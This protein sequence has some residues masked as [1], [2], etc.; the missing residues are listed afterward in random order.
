MS[1]YGDRC[2]NPFNLPVHRKIKDLRKL[3]Q[4]LAKKWSITNKNLYVC[5]QCR[6][7]LTREVPLIISDNVLLSSQSSQSSVQNSQESQG[8]YY[9]PEENTLTKSTQ[10]DDVKSNDNE[11]LLQLKEKFNDPSTS[12]SMKTMILTLAPKSWSEKKLADEFRT[13]RRQAKKAKELVEQNGILSSPN[14]RE[15]RKLTSEVRDLV[16]TFYLREDNTRI[17]PGKKDFVSVKLHDGNR[18]HL[19]KQLIMCNINELYQQFKLEYPATKVGLSK[20]FSLRPKQCILAGDSGTHV[21]CVCIYHQNVKLMLSGGN[22]SSLTS[23]SAIPLTSYKDCL[24]KMMCPDPTPTCHLMTGK[25]SLNEQC[26]NCPGLD[27]IREHLTRI[28]D[29]NQ[30]TNV[31]FDT[32]VGTDSFT[33]TTRVL[34]SDE[35]VDSL[36]SA[37]DILKPHAYIADQQTRYF[38][39]LKESILEGENIIQCDFAENY[40]FV[41]QDAAQSFHWNNDQATLLTSVFYYKKDQNLKHGSIVMISDDLKHDTATY[42]TFQKLLHQHLHEKS[43]STK[44]YIY[45]TDGAS[46]HFKNRFNFINLFYFKQDFGTDAEFHFHATSHGKGPCDGLGGNLKRLATRA[47]LQSASNNAITTSERLYEWARKSLPQ[48]HVFYARKEDIQQ[49]RIFLKSRFESA[50]T[51]PGTKKYHAFIPITEG[52]MVKHTSNSEAFKIVKICK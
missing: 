46:Q 52:I 34:P 41:V 48:T 40:S 19:Q 8:L 50:A 28:F 23:E 47:S 42:Y 10:T 16:T 24:Q 12:V 43:I 1:P 17:L 44:K 27:E 38:Q 30:V 25:S 15:G 49:N 36:C 3:S 5:K 9:V 31:Q 13:S 29:E 18:V 22:I 11:I 2:Y 51:I 32:W 39:L 35:Y 45:I 37:L 6:E 7:R 26:H 21:V 4:V 14:P 33:I 20:F